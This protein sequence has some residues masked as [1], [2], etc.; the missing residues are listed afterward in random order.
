MR[1]RYFNSVPV[2]R[3][4]LGNVPVRIHGP[5]RVPEVLFPGFA[6]DVSAEFTVGPWREPVDVELE[7]GCAER[8]DYD[9]ELRCEESLRARDVDFMALVDAA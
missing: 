7:D 4:L 9:G 1:E 5:A 8:V 2:L 3:A 6:A